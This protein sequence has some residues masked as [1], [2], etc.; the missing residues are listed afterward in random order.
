MIN[1]WFVVVVVLLIIITM[2]A[3]CHSCSSRPA[4]PS[5]TV[6]AVSSGRVNLLQFGDSIRSVGTVHI[7]GNFF[8]D[9]TQTDSGLWVTG[10]T[11]SATAPKF[12]SLFSV[13]V[14][15][16]TAAVHLSLPWPE[17]GAY[18]STE[19]IEGWALFSFERGSVI[20][21][22]DSSSAPVMI[23]DVTGWFRLSETQAVSGDLAESICVQDGEL[24]RETAGASCVRV[25]SRREGL[26]VYSLDRSRWRFVGRNSASRG[27]CL[28]LE[29]EV[30]SL[31]S[32][33]DAGESSP[34]FFRDGYYDHYMKFV[35][36]VDGNI[37]IMRAMVD[38]G[39]TKF[40]VG[41]RII[42]YDADSMVDAVVID[43]AG[44]THL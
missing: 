40:W 42:S 16:L 20:A 11:S 27:S 36:S 3:C 37:I 8:H 12:V 43:S 22:L 26:L 21:P 10:V 19:V 28:H 2:A 41:G 44:A 1:K 13:D 17:F 24:H 34:V 33:A 32:L 23:A 4:P 5:I 30:Q 14:S 18:R 35:G 15:Q 7:P 39:S 31:L 6:L 38:Y 29:D 9:V 25:E